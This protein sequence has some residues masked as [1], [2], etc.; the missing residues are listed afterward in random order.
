MFSKTSPK[1]VCRKRPPGRKNSSH[2]FSTGATRRIGTRQT[3]L[4]FVDES[5]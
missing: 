1:V 2:R 5:E 4:D 3:T